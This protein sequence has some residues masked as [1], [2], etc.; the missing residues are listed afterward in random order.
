M[1]KDRKGKRDRKKSIK[2]KKKDR[3]GKRDRKNDLLAQ[4]K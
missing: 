2:E 3:K 1:S 4:G